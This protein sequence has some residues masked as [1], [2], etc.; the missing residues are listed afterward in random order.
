MGLE[1]DFFLLLPMS[2]FEIGV[3]DVIGISAEKREEEKTPEA[4]MAPEAMR[5]L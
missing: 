1:N 2:Q 4:E 5:I 3:A